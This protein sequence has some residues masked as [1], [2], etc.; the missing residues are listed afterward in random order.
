MFVE[1]F[2]AFKSMDTCQ[3]YIICV[4]VT[5]TVCLRFMHCWKMVK[6]GYG[7]LQGQDQGQIKE[8]FQR[9]SKLTKSATIHC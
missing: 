3:Y 4:C 2:M 6:I 1:H 9:I 7:H 5:F 8:V